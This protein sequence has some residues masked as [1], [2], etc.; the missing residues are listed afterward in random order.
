M[1]P[2]QT[3]A[4]QILAND[5]RKRRRMEAAQTTAELDALAYELRSEGLTWEAIAERIGYANGAIARRAALRHNPP[6]T[7]TSS[8][9]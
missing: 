5:A 3:D 2:P 7:N 6:A 9:G 4:E 1:L 8:E